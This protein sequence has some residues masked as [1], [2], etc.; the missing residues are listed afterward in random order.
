MRPKARFDL[1]LKLRA[2]EATLGEVFA[3]M[4]GL[5]F[6]GKLAYVEAFAGT[7]AH[8]IVPGRG[9]LSPRHP[10]TLA[11]LRKM[12]D[13]PVDLD[14]RRYV[15]PLVRDA[16]KLRAALGTETPVVLLG[17]IATR[18]YTEPLGRIFGERLLVPREFIGKGDMSRG[19][20]MLKCV[21]QGRELEYVAA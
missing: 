15:K 7:T 9:L 20:L 13:I 21:A 2:G 11:E 17:S 19:S 5:Y 1:A 4:S 12:A 14:E 8:V 6:R 3:F 16:T 18:K 10:V